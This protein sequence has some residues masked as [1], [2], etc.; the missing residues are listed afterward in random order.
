[1]RLRL[2]LLALALSVALPAIAAQKKALFDNTHAETAGNADWQLDTDQPVPVPTQVNVTW[3]TPRT[4]WLGAVSSWGIDLVKRGY[5]VAT[6]TTAYGITYGNAGNAYDLS[7]FDVFIVPEPNTRFT[8]AESTAIFN[9]V[10]NGG[11]LVTVATTTP[12]ATTTAWTLPRSGAASIASIS[13]ALTSTA[14]GK[15][16]T[17]SPRTAETST[18]HSTTR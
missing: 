18:P 13:G 3:A 6:L 5:S 16:T 12:T 9:Y 4:Y 17:T 11:G 14:R 2:V 8:A 1:M 15:P 10:W 7:N